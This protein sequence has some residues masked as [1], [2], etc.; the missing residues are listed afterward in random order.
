MS[1][2]HDAQV[3]ALTKHIRASLPDLKTARLS[4][5]YY[6]ASLPLCVIDAVFSIGVRYEST[7]NT[8]KKWCEAQTPAWEIVRV[9]RTNRPDAPTINTFMNLLEGKD[10]TALAKEVFC[11]QQRTSSRNGI[12]K[13]K[14]V[15]QFADVL[16]KN[17]INTF[18]D[19]ENYCRNEKIRAK[20]RGIKGQKSGISF[21]YFLML[22][23][24][25]GHIK[26]DRML[27]DFVADVLRETV[28]VDK[29]RALVL[30]SCER[31][32]AEICH[33]KPR[34]L[35]YEIWKYQRKFRRVGRAKRQGRVLCVSRRVSA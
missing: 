3:T 10:F 6:Y 33:L 32:Q 14:A 26:A 20:I 8:V 28:S 30:S 5:E 27:R 4:K 9:P 13:V 18:G 1:D 29:T 15:Y 31:L 22:A 2:T 7:Q 19:T 24:S 17:G 11:N 25:D 21:D 12:L 23:G 34:L 16:R 35:D